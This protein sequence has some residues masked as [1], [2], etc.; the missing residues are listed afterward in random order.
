MN[1]TLVVPILGAIGL[2]LTG[3]AQLYGGKAKVR[4][5][6]LSHHDRLL[7]SL[8]SHVSFLSD[9]EEVREKRID[10][11]TAHTTR[12]DRENLELRLDLEREKR[13]RIEEREEMR[14]RIQEL[15]RNHP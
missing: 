3:L 15:E 4:E 11:L 12:C 5:V 10:E 6:T 13:E 14:D 1:L 8:Q 2:I 7:A 9:R